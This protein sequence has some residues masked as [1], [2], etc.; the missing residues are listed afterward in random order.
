[1]A[2]IPTDDYRHALALGEHEAF[3]FLFTSLDGQV[4]GFLRTLFG[5]DAVLE[6][7]ALHAGGQAWA[8][9][10][11][12]ALRDT[13]PVP[14]DASGPA[15]QLTCLQPW[16][17]WRSRFEGTLQAVGN[18]AALQAEL[19][20]T[21]TATVEPAYY[22]FR[23][24]HQ[25]QQDGRLSG[26]LRAGT[27][28]WTGDLVCYRDHSWGQRPMGAAERWTI[29]S[30]PDYFYIV[31]T[32]IENQ[33]MCFGRFATPE[34]RFAPVRAPSITAVGEDWRIEDP[35]AGLDAWQV[36][37]L[38]PPLTAYLGPAGQEA[39]RGAPRPGDLYR[40]DIGP[41]LFTAPGGKR[42]VG[43]WDQA[44]RLT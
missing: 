6:L 3:Y 39:L 24:Y 20:L 31:V 44:R 32:E 17:A 4:H 2:L 38:A 9:Q 34:D 25:G 41:A 26:H 28:T 13:P 1:M 23:S 19:D 36:Q 37:R 43:F 15:L 40:D 8:N 29:A 14:T 7:V 18:E 33:R 12:A 16:Q 22:G 27:Q 42:V 10:Q 21:Y 30:A 35:Q 11:R 5:Q